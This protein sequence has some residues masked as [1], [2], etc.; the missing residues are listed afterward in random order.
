MLLPQ[1]GASYTNKLEPISK[2]QFL[3]LAETLITLAQ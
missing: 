3:T 1:T 2:F